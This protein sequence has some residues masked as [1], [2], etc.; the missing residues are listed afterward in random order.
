MTTPNV[1]KGNSL[2]EFQNKMTKGQENVFALSLK[3]LNEKIMSQPLDENGE[4]IPLSFDDFY[5]DL[6]FYET[7]KIMMAN[8]AQ[9][10]V[11]EFKKA[12]KIMQKEAQIEK[13]I[14]EIDGMMELDSYQLISN[15]RASEVKNRIRVRFNWLLSKQYQDRNFFLYHLDDY[16][17]LDSS[18]SRRLYELFQMVYYRSD[19][20]NAKGYLFKPSVDELKEY[21]GIAEGS[22]YDKFP[23]FNQKVIKKA[24]KE[25]N[26]NTELTVTQK[27]VKRGRYVRWIEFQMYRNPDFRNEPMQS[28]MFGGEIPV[29]E[30]PD[31][32]I[33]EEYHKQLEG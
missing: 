15:I 7:Q 17:A 26:K 11:K 27:N 6:E 28:D 8:Y 10:R 3:A 9:G 19:K 12:L 29:R 2:Y 1:R 25:I 20:N 16:L 14:E 18:H 4:L 24:I 30:I 33:L 23:E 21:L 32:S 22:T 5:V 31:H 13:K